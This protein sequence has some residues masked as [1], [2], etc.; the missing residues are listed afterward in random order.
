MEKTLVSRAGSQLRAIECPKC[1]DIILHP[2][3]L[4]SL[5]HF[6]NIKGKTFNVKLRVVGNSHA[7]S[8]PKE[9]INFIKEQ[10]RAMDDMVKLCFRDMHRLNLIFGNNEEENEKELEEYENER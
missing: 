5:Q 6:N 4:N 7:I 3:D 2:S 9:I 8:I 10:E 1:K